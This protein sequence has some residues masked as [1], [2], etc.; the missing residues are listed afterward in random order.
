MVAAWKNDMS[1]LQILLK[2]GAQIVQQDAVCVHKSYVCGFR[3]TLG[4]EKHFSF[5]IKIS[6]R[7]HVDSLLS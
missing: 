4:V 3:T 5:K 1:L 6:W 2:K 7:V